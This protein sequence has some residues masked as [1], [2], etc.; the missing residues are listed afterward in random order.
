M[1]NAGTELLLN[2]SVRDNNWKSCLNHP[3]KFEQSL[4]ER[5]WLS[6]KITFKN[7]Q[8]GQRE[9]DTLYYS[10]NF[11]VLLLQWLPDNENNTVISGAVDGICGKRF[12]WM[13]KFLLNHKISGHAFTSPAFSV[14][15]HNQ[16]HKELSSVARKIAT[17]GMVHT[18]L[19]PP[20][21]GAIQEL[22]D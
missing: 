5:A 2:S 13:F 12:I 6:G 17:D 20:H 8:T 21:H 11:I 14:Q 18:E 15:W 3:W 9:A 19:W 22:C 7:K 1:K 10:A 4:S 16:S